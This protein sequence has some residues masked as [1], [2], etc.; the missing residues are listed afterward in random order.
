MRIGWA[1]MTVKCFGS[2]REMVEVSNALVRRGH[3]VTIYH[4]T[5]G[6][7]DWLP[8]LART[9]TLDEARRAALDVLIAFPEFTVETLF[10]VL[11]DSPAILKAFVVAGPTP[12]PE[13]AA[14]LRGEREPSGSDITRWRD[15]MLVD[16]YTVLPDSD[17]QTDW[18][19]DVVGYA[20]VGPG[21]GGV[22]LDMFRPC[23]AEH[24]PDNPLV[25]W[26]GDRRDRKGG[27][28]IDAAL[29]IIWASRPEVRVESYWGRHLEQMALAPWLSRGDLFL[30]AHRRAGWCN[31]VVEAMACGVPVV[32]TDIPA[33]QMLGD[34]VVRVP[35]DDAPALAEA[36]LRVL[37]DCRIADDMGAG[38]LITT[39][40]FSYE[41]MARRLEWFLLKR[42]DKADIP[43]RPLSLADI[44]ER[45]EAGRIALARFSDGSFFCLQGKEGANCDG[46]VYT[47]EQAAA[48][49]E[50][51]DND[52]VTHGLLWVAELRA[53]AL[54]WCLDNDVQVA[55]YR[56]DAIGDASEDGA[57]WKFRRCLYHKRVVMVGPAHLRRF[58]AWP[59]VGFVECPPSTALEDVDRLESETYALA[60]QTDAEVILFSCGQAASPTL[61]SRLSRKLV[62]VS[63]LDCGSVWDMYVGVLSRSGP[64]RMGKE[65]IIELGRRNFHMEV[66]AWWIG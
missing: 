41:R 33:T 31:P 6:D 39:L 12:T 36:A 19:R 54:R 59:V 63:L 11:H 53:D 23:A 44:I 38:G 37:T 20:D 51:L 55:W 60:L 15:A 56:G 22:N 42:L 5:G 18:L 43:V 64:K 2:V 1:I 62:D 21:F 34:A 57:L 66:G 50:C 40:Q 30:D 35:I 29:E 16:R 25:L 8:C 13:L 49:R 52:L 24:D 27:D 58:G 3:D 45:I 7:C 61:V 46:V 14:E 47:P 48:L 28:T 10:D 26:S 65:H 4:P 32:C 17:W 9:G